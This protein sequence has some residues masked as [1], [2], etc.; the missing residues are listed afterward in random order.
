MQAGEES[1]T[2]YNQ[3]TWEQHKAINYLALLTTGDRKSFISYTCSLK[4]HGKFA[5]SS[6][7]FPR[8]HTSGEPNKPETARSAFGL[9]L[10]EKKKCGTWKSSLKWLM[11]MLQCIWGS[12][13]NTMADGVRSQGGS[14][15]SCRERLKISESS[16]LIYYI[17][18]GPGKFRFCWKRRRVH[19]TG[20][21]EEQHLLLCSGAASCLAAW[22]CCQAHLSLGGC[23]KS[24]WWRGSFLTLENVLCR[25]QWVDLFLT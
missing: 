7:T 18:K 19:D 6:E 22:L 4:A 11:L 16:F 12:A 14:S 24:L 9:G 15:S 23:Y 8:G 2:Q 1:F 5:P 10:L 13:E 25:C 21:R 17:F 3:Q 20:V